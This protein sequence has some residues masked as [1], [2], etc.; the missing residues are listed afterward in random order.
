MDSKERLEVV[1]AITRDLTTLPT[2]RDASKLVKLTTNVVNH[3]KKLLEGAPESVVGEGK[4][5]LA[6]FV[7][8]TRAVA[9]DPSTAGP[10]ALK[11]L[12]ASKQDVE[13]LVKRLNNWHATRYAGSERKSSMEINFEQIAPSPAASPPRSPVSELEQS[14]VRRVQ[15]ARQE[16]QLRK[17]VRPSNSLEEEPHTILKAAVLVLNS[18]VQEMEQELSK[19]SPGPRREP[20]L[21]PLLNLT[22]HV[23]K[24]LDLEDTLFVAKF[25]MRKQV[26]VCV[27]V[28]VCV[29]V[30]VCVR[31]S[32]YVCVRA[33]TA[34]S[35]VAEKASAMLAVAHQSSAMLCT[36]SCMQ[37]QVSLV[38]AL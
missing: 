36:C 27:C 37:S 34:P 2:E 17:E 7:L 9:Q 25:P 11:T 3:A 22:Q 28:C 38:L 13:V 6:Q 32:V 15:A 21:E 1:G 31:V 29:R 18:A 8:A 5:V 35:Y 24:L 26:C 14:L 30:R 12:A 19:E 10:K 23:C 4:T 20:L 33:C 16:L